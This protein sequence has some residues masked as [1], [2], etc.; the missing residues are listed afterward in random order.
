MRAL[1]AAGGLGPLALQALALLTNGWEQ[2]FG[3]AAHLM[4][5]PREQGFQGQREWHS[6]D[7]FARALITDSLHDANA[8]CGGQ[9]DAMIARE[10]DYLVGARRQDGVGAWSYFPELVELPPDIDDL[11]QVMLALMRGGRD[12][13]PH[14]A[15][16]LQTALQ[17]GRHDDGA[18]DTWIVPRARRSAAQQCQALWVSQA[19]G[20]GADVE[21]MANLLHVLGKLDARRHGSTIVAGA[22]YIAARQLASGAWQSSWYHGPY[23]GCYQCLRLLAGIAPQHPAVQRACTFLL[24]TQLSNGA[25]ALTAAGH[26]DALSSALAVLALC[27]SRRDDAIQAA[28]A[29]VRA[30]AELGRSGPWPA[31][32]F[33]RMD[34]GRA[35]GKVRHTLTYQS[36]L[37]TAAFVLKAACALP[38]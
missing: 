10:L 8:L 33:I 27:A 13:M 12:P 38:H 17:D 2:A 28:R 6:G 29:G 23:Y 22:N 14:C 35:D 20:G 25:W 7:I 32:P 1:A 5:F 9:L 31:V 19:W 21:V 26:A 36:E 15:A 18:L 37:V 4:H 34:L 11:A 30:L 3:S 24:Q 16:A